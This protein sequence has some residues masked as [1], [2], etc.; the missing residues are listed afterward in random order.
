ME[1]AVRYLIAIGVPALE[2]M[3]DKRLA[4]ANRLHIRAFVRVVRAIGDPARP[5]LGRK[6]L[7]ATDDEWPQLLRIA[8]DASVS[9]FGAMLPKLIQ[10][11]PDMRLAAVRAAG[12]F[13]ARGTVPHIQALLIDADDLMRRTAMVSLAQIGDP[14]ALGTASAMLN[15]SDP[16]IRD[17][18]MQILLTEP[19]QAV[20]VARQ[21]VV[22][23]DEVKA[24]IGLVML[25]KINMYNAE[26]DVISALTDPRPGL[27]I[28]ALQ[29]L[30]GKCPESAK[31]AFLALKSDP[32]PIVRA[33][34]QKLNP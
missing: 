29:L 32:V 9:D 30:A 19:E 33:V 8:V 28:T 16:I 6:A 31:E 3:L 15:S 13:K 7:T 18:A 17:A 12:V 34:A 14:S 25:A 26:S 4:T 5:V 11:K 20:A 24:R 1:Q 2:W 27:R 23:T 10:E 22:G 21:L